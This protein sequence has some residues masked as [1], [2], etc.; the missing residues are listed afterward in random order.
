MT[1]QTTSGKLNSI[2]ILTH[3]ILNTRHVLWLSSESL[4][5]MSAFQTKELFLKKE[6]FVYN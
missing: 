3:Q 5:I 6:T 2:G 4:A 1:S